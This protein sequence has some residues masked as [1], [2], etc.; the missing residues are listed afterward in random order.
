MRFRFATP[1]EAADP[2]FVRNLSTENE[3][4]NIVPL[5][6]AKECDASPEII[7]EVCFDARI[8]ALAMPC[9]YC[10]GCL[11]C[12]AKLSTKECPICRV[13]I[14]EVNRIYIV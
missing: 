8:N 6:E 7:F 10:F 4:P 1:E 14:L 9:R 2:T 13:L 11:N 12:T 5:S 3:E